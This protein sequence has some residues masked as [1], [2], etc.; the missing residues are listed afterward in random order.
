MLR[1]QYE[2]SLFITYLMPNAPPPPLSIIGSIISQSNLC[3]AIKRNLSY[4]HNYSN[5]KGL[6]ISC[7]C[8]LL[9][10]HISLYN[11]ATPA[12]SQL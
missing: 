4:A 10:L 9:I 6:D 5:I 3:G 7:A 8:F 1:Y 12:P 2:C 11:Y